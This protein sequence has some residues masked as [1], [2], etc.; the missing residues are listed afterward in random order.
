MLKKMLPRRAA[1]SRKNAA[2]VLAKMLPAGQ[3]AGENLEKCCPPDLARDRIWKNARKSIAGAFRE[4]NST[5]IGQHLARCGPNRAKLGRVRPKLVRFGQKLAK[6]WHLAPGAQKYLP[7][8]HRERCSSTFPDT[9]P[10]PIRRGAFFQV[11]FRVSSGRQQFGEHSSGIRSR[12]PP[13]GAVALFQHVE[14]WCD[15]RR[16]KTGEHA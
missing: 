1:A 5:Q 10:R 8:S 12:R 2:K 6:S 7:K 4:P 14:G 3:D 11:I 9:V 16:H 13:R 15:S